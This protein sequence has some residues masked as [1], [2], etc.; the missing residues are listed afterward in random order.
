V[1]S[2]GQFF[3][4]SGK[5]YKIQR[6]IPALSIRQELAGQIGKCHSAHTKFYTAAFDNGTRCRWQRGFLEAMG[7]SFRLLD[8][9]AYCPASVRISR[10][11]CG[12]LRVSGDRW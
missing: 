1:L 3:K 5:P 7:V 6:G 12:L 10:H 8:S 4:A 11:E 9:L 2:F